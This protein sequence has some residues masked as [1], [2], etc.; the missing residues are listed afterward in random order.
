LSNNHDNKIA[1]YIYFIELIIIS[2]AILKLLSG[3]L[4]WSP[5]G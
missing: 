4:N 1:K 3:I 2:I 5:F